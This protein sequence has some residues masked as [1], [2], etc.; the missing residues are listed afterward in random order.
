MSQTLLFYNDIW[1]DYF[2]Y[3]FYDRTLQIHFTS[4]Y[5]I[6]YLKNEYY[7]HLAWMISNKEILK[8]CNNIGY[9]MF[10]KEKL[11]FIFK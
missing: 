1:E 2:T 9:N 11:V 5:K 4:N 8:M 7:N 6:A 10:S 3:E